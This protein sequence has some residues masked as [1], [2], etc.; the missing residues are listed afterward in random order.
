MVPIR[1]VDV[2]LTLVVA[3]I[4]YQ[5]IECA[6]L[7]SRLYGAC[8]PSVRTPERPRHLVSAKVIDESDD[9]GW[10]WDKDYGM[11]AHGINVHP[12]LATVTYLSTKGGPTIILEKTVSFVCLPAVMLYGIFF[13]CMLF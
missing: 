13:V 12:C 10:H 3:A 4:R 9:I 8:P 5:G 1:A 2:W 7:A 11:E 6:R